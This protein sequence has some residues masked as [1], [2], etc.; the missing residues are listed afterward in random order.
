[1]TIQLREEASTTIHTCNSEKKSKHNIMNNSENKE[2]TKKIKKK[3]PRCSFCSIKIKT[4][5]NIK[6]RC[7]KSFC[8]KHFL[9]ENHECTY[10]FK[11]DKIKLEKVVAEKVIPI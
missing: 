6:C 7:G 3:K 11:K 9:P 5:S 2:P 1:M 4:F 8:K 10:D